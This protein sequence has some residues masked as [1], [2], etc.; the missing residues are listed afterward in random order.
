MV[1]YPTDFSPD[2]AGPAAASAGSLAIL[3]VAGL[4]VAA[5]VAAYLFA[6]YEQTDRLKRI[7]EDKYSKIKDAVEK[8]MGTSAD[9]AERAAHEL[10]SSLTKHLGPLFGWISGHSKVWADLEK[11]AS[12]SDVEPKRRKVDAV[13]RSDLLHSVESGWRVGDQLHVLVPEPDTRPSQQKLRS[14]RARKAIEA[15]HAFWIGGDPSAQRTARLGDLKAMQEAL[16]VN[17]PTGDRLPGLSS[18]SKT[19]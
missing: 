13:A 16:A 18:S 17:P 12:F 14:E 8:A 9:D 15:F 1:N 3:L 10:R 19:T 4:I 6:R 7:R 11:A 2:V 5:G